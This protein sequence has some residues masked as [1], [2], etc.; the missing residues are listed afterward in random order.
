MTPLSPTRAATYPARARARTPALRPSYLPDRAFCP[1]CGEPSLMRH[2][3]DTYSCRRCD[4]A[5]EVS[6]FAG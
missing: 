3:G 6:G 2:T 1:A 4:L 5:G